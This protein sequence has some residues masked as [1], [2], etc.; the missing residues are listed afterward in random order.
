[1]TKAQI[2]MLRKNANTMMMMAKVM[3]KSGCEELMKIYANRGL[4]MCKK[5]IEIEKEMELD[6]TKEY[7]VNL[8][9]VA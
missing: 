7:N 6:Y 3:K 9:L 4:S 2:I 1:M 5:I 8:R